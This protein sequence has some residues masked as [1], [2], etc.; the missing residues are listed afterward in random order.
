MAQLLERRLAL[1][2]LNMLPG[3]GPGRKK[4]LSEFLGPPEEILATSETVLSQIHGIGPKLAHEI[5]HWEKY[6]NPMEELKLAEQSGIRIITDEDDGYPSMLREIHDPPIC[7]YVRGSCDL[8]NNTSYAVAIVGSRNASSYGM[9]M[10]GKLATEAS[11]AG[12]PVISGLARGI[13]TAAH[14]ATLRAGGRTIAVIG[15]GMGCIYPPENVPLAMSIIE[16][17]GAV[18]TEFPIRYQPDRRSFPMRNR[19]ISG[20][21]RGT[22]VVEAG[23]KSGSLITAAQAMEQNRTVFA[24]PGMADSPFSKGCHAL[25]RD[26]AVLTE[27]FQDVIDDFTGLP[28][29]KEPK[30]EKPTPPPKVSVK[31]LHLTGLER[32]LWELILRGNDNMDDI[33]D[34]SDEEP[35]CVIAA[36]LALEL[37][38]LIRQMPGRKIKLLVDASP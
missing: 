3:M 22:I 29:L 20:L 12:S 2:A 11:Y 16:R 13:D 28:G 9:R 36:L 31:D 23:Q 4:L 38:R 14:E 1:L 37:K 35:S 5:S 10:A 34:L 6:C 18:V 24:V 7:L 26:G 25:L 27:S 15:S 8:L 30:G 21:S 17:G 32:K 33:I 19:I